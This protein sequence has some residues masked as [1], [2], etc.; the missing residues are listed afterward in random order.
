MMPILRF[1]ASVCAAS[2]LGAS[3]SAAPPGAPAPRRFDIP[4]P[5]PPV[6]T[7]RPQ[8]A[9]KRP[10]LGLDVDVKL[11][12]KVPNGRTSDAVVGADGGASG[13]L[14]AAPAGALAVRWSLPFLDRAPFLALEV[15]YYRLSGSGTRDLATDPDFGPTLAYEWSMDAIPISIGGG[16]RIARVGPVGFSAGAGL[17]VVAVSS[18]ATYTGSSTGAK[19]TNADRSGVAVGGYFGVEG[20]LRLGPGSL[21]GELRHTSARTDLGL[22]SAHGA[23]VAISP[24]DVEGTSVLAGYRVSF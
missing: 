3:A 23:A 22:A 5:P 7:P 6:P 1:A 15:G 12:L 2:L 14:G 9:V 8:A 4:L 20:A 17:A 19:V 24:G 13:G 16:F 10:G 18:R 11:A 21:V